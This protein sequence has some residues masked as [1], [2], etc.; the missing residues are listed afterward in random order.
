M[1]L[2]SETRL[3]TFVE[4]EIHEKEVLLESRHQ[5]AVKIISS[6]EF[7]TAPGYISL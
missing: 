3:A 7:T 6:Q 4:T 2:S 1:K 5:I